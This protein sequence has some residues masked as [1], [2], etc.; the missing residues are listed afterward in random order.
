MMIQLKY[1]PIELGQGFPTNF[2]NKIDAKGKW[3]LSI[4]RQ[5]RETMLAQ[6]MLD[7]GKIHMSIWLKDFVKKF[8]PKERGY[9]ILMNKAHE[10]EQE[11][12]SIWK[13]AF[14]FLIPSTD[15]EDEKGEERGGEVK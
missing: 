15:K 4:E 8:M 11:S 9:K 13:K 14:G 1:T 2:Y 3:A 6:T 12:I 10:V 7:F 5:F